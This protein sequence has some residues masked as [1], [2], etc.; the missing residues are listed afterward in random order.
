MA[1]THALSLSAGAAPVAA[2]I[3][4]QIRRW[5]RFGYLVLAA[6]FGVGA[7]WS[8]AAPL[9]SAVLAQGT[10]KVDSSRKKVQHAEGGVVKD[11]LVRDG[12]TVTAGQVLVR[13]DEIRAGAAHGMV[14]GGRDVAMASEA[15]LLAERD[16][17]PRIAFPEGLLKRTAAEP[18]VA[19]IMAAQET[20][21]AARRSA[22]AGELGIIDQQIAALM[23]EIDGFESQRQSKDAQMDSL[24][25]DLRA[26]MELDREGMV[27]RTRLRAIERDIAKLKGERDELSSRIATART[28]I[29]E[30]RLK[31]FQVNRAFKEDVAAE[32]KKVQTENYELIEREQATR[33]SLE[34]ME[35]RAPVAGTVTELKAHTPGG[36]VGA[37][38]VLMEIVPADDRL[39]IEA[40][41][42]PA[43]VDRVLVG[44]RAGVKFQAF[45]RRTLPE[46]TGEV[47]Y[48]SPDAV[49]DPRTETAHFLVKVSVPAG[50]MA[51]LEDQK[52]QPGMMADVFIRTGQRTFAGY[53]LEPLTDSF[54]KAWLER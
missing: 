40:R 36:F 45:N 49:T 9:S 6:T 21:F 53:L 19:Q 31:K 22:R 50:E 48:V 35:L 16:D 38:E 17:L 13:M 26:L 37:G 12:A 11:I 28:A 34:L 3:D 52:V 2:P 29:A 33:R 8:V 42:L 54:S 39:V 46:L 18:Q 7:L 5:T 27:E 10:V 23:S 41:V 47:V 43:D 14:T 15:R 1:D 25:G 44:Q 4:D 30:Q 32:L 20:L 51:R 24:Q